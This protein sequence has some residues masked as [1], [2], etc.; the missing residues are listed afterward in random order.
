[1][2]LLK[3]PSEQNN[4]PESMLNIVSTQ[5][6]DVMG[7][8]RSLADPTIIQHV[9]SDSIKEIRFVMG[10]IAS[11]RK[12]SDVFS[13]VGP[14]VVSWKHP[15]YGESI[16][17]QAFVGFGKEISTE[18]EG[19]VYVPVFEGW[20]SNEQSNSG[21]ITHFHLKLLRESN[22]ILQVTN[23]QAGDLWQRLQVICFERFSAQQVFTY[24]IN[25]EGKTPIWFIDGK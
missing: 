13:S 9:D 21:I 18:G 24:H 25:S 8:I 1:M 6:E 4:N 17:E 10:D 19:V 12:D 11:F 15:E 23:G 5:P 3:K 7:E 14:F 20:A 2:N 16:R 22:G